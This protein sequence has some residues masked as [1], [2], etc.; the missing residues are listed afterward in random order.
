[1][2]V[3][4]A[5]SV[6][7]ATAGKS[8]TVSFTVKSAGKGVKGSVSCSA[9]LDGKPLAGRQSVSSS[10]HASCSWSLP[11]SSHG[12][13]LTGSISESYKGSKVSRSFSAKVT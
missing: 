8:F 5:F 12:K 4:T 11:F 2:L 1:M 10:G 6:G 9:K 7:K 13:R 3:V